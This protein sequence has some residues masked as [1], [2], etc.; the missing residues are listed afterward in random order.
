LTPGTGVLAGT[1]PNDPATQ[2]ARDIRTVNQ[3][4]QKTTSSVTINAQ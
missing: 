1:N 4:E 3:I 2:A